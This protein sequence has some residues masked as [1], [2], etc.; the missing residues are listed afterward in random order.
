MSFHDTPMDAQ[1]RGDVLVQRGASQAVQ[2]LLQ[3]IEISRLIEMNATARTAGNSRDAL[4]GT[5]ASRFPPLRFPTL[6]D[7]KKGDSPSASGDRR[8]TALRFG[9]SRKIEAE[10]QDLE[11]NSF[12]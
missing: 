3:S 11:Q 7:E 12:T 2:I 5:V 10:D 9:R 4:P 6:S 8:H 1:A